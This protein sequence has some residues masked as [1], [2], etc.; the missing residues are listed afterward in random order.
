[1][2]GGCINQVVI[3]KKKRACQLMDFTVPEDHSVKIK[4]SEK[5]KKINVRFQR[6]KNVVK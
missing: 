4:E 3:E 5:R 6:A 2:N 1:M